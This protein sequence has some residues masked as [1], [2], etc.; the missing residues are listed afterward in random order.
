VPQPGILEDER[1]IDGRKNEG[2]GEKEGRS[3]LD[4]ILP[5]E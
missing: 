4:H 2:G 3:I 1:K 5:D